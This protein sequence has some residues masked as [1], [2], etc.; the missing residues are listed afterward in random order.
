[1]ATPIATVVPL[2]WGVISGGL[3]LI[4]T[5]NA[6]FIDCVRDKNFVEIVEFFGVSK[7]TK[8]IAG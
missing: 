5:K 1:M 3:W 4:V 6:G 2:V 8:G 7:Y